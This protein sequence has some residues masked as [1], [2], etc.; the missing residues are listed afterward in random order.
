[1]KVLKCLI[2]CTG[3]VMFFSCAGTGLSVRETDPWLQSME[4]ASRINI[5]GVWDAGGAITGGWGE[6][7]FTQKGNSVSGT[8]GFYNVNGVVSGTDIY[9]VLTSS[10]NVYYTAHLKQSSEGN[11]IGKAVEG[12]IVDKKGSE[13][14]TS[15]LMVLRQVSNVPSLTRSVTTAWLNSVAGTAAVNITGVWD[16]G[17]AITGGWGEGRFIQTGNHISGTLGFYNVDGVVNGTNVYLALYA[18]A[19]VY[20]TAHLQPSKD[21]SYT[22]RVAERAII[23]QKGA[24]GAVKYHMILKK[25]S[26]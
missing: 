4:G 24:E 14:A 15:Y 23:G 26:M 1:M 18:H 13:E 2:I 25:V 9:M 21:G 7:R 12:A 10:G 20:Y 16:A 5:T 11:Y 22:G 17:G 8:L 6:G 19:A 3:I